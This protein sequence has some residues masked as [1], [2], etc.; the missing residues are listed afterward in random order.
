MQAIIL[1]LKDAMGMPIVRNSQLLG[2]TC[3]NSHNFTKTV[4]NLER[5]TFKAL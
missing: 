5:K 3:S 1:R 2:G 4:V